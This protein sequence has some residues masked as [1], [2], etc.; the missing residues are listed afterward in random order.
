MSRF[1]NI[2]SGYLLL[3]KGNTILLS[4]RYNTGYEDG[5]YSV[6]AGHLEE[7]ETI[8]QC[9]IRE[10]LE[11]VGITIQPENLDLVHV[12]H[13]KQEDERIDY[14]FLVQQWGGE[15]TNNEP[16]KCDDLQWFPLDKLPENTIPY[17]R[18]A[19]EMYQKKVIYSEFGW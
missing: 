18:S 6:P 17:I 11:E 8:R 9:A 12:M 1:K 4:R 14:F 7:H 15:I 10:G 5:K 2:T 16:D 13:R 19:I 3:V